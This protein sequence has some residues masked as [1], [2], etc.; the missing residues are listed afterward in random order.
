MAIGKILQAPLILLVYIIFGASI[1]A[2]IKDLIGFPTV[3]FLG[4]IVILHIIGVFINI[5]KRKVED[6]D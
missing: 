6:V 1:Y 4:V 5:R 2:F 3:I